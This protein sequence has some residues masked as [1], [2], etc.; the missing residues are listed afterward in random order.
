MKNPKK[1][2]E[3]YEQLRELVG[4]QRVP[5]L[6]ERKIYKRIFNGEMLQ[7][8]GELSWAIMLVY[9]AGKAKGAGMITYEGMDKI[10]DRMVEQEAQKKTSTTEN[11]EGIEKLNA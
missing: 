7:E 5:N 8:N 1:Q 10:V 9:L 2:I 6:A 4:S 3:N 11:S